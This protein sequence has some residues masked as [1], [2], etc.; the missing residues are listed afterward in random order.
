[1]KELLNEIDVARIETDQLL[2]K[3]ETRVSSN[4]EKELYNTFYTI[5]KDLR[6]QL[7]K[8]QD[9]GQSNNEEAYA[10]YLKEVDPNMKK[11]IQAIR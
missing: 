4:R 2:K 7:K 8:V 9:L 6:T 10:Y 11:S 5:F 3:F 1:I